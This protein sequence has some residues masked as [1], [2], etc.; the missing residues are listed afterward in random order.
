[1]HKNLYALYYDLPCNTE[2]CRNI[3]EEEDVFN[4][5][6]KLEAAVSPVTLLTTHQTARRRTSESRSVI[7]QHLGISERNV[8]LYAIV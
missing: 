6:L 7:I 3:S 1:L 8:S 5:T 4:F 2:N